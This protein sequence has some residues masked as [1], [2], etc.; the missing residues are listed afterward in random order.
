M[1]LEKETFEKL[2]KDFETASQK[3]K[4]ICK[5][6]YCGIIFDRMKHNI[7]RSWEHVKSDSCSDKSCVQKKR[8]Q[9]NQLLFG[10]DNAF[11]NEDVKKKIAETNI[12]NFG[13][14]N[15]FQ[16]ADV[17]EKQRQT[18]RE[19]YG[20]PNVFQ[21]EDV[22]KKL[23]QTIEA[24][25][26][27]SNPTKDKS[28]KK[29]QEATLTEIYGVPHALQH[30]ELRKKAMETCITNFGK[31]PANNYGKT[32]KSI[33]DWLNS[34]GFNFK[35]NRKLIPGFEIDMY[36]ADKKFG[37]EYCGLHWHHEFSSVSHSNPKYHHN[38]YTKCLD[39]GIHL[40]TIFSD[41][42]EKRRTQCEG[43]IKSLLGIHNERVFGRKCI[44]KEID[45]EVGRKFFQ[46]YHIQGQNKLG[47]I[48]FG[49]YHADELCGVISLGRHNR[50]YNAL[51]LDRLCFKHGTQVVGGASKLFSR[52]V[53]WAKAQGHQEIISFSDNRWSLGNVYEALK[54]EMIKDYRPDYSYVDVKKP[55]ERISKQSQKKGVTDCPD[56]MTEYDWAHTR[57]LARIW[58]CGK[59]R[60]LFRIK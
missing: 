4:I 31:F 20:V 7:L 55:N 36:D 30:P 5:C 9:T 22:K 59:K 37:I 10:T 6:D 12:L 15:A 53:E 42:W 18:C 3:S 24:K 56:G 52:C 19:R 41:E 50:Q 44:V 49:L 29:K 60:W 51:V 2:G 54:F 21:H 28:I 47:I 48:F 40:L 14:A 45:K 25:Y 35:S 23:M 43:H 11:Q 58:D 32:Q 13:V 38:K 57:G 17:Q 16:N 39:Q 27:V 26:G 34:F 33:E 8:V 46:E 1:I